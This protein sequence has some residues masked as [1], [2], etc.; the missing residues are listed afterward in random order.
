MGLWVFGVFFFGGDVLLKVFFKGLVGIIV[1]FFAVL[2]Q[3]LVF[4]CSAGRFAK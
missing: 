2:M 4:G 1:L 3:I